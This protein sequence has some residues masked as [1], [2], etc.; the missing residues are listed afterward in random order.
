MLRFIS[1]SSVIPAQARCSGLD[2]WVLHRATR[3]KRLSRLHRRPACA[4]AVPPAHARRAR[5][6]VSVPAQQLGQRLGLQ[7]AHHHTR[8]AAATVHGASS[9]L[10]G[11]SGGAR[12]LHNQGQ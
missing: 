9:A 12:C 11:G 8:E 2:W 10:C 4:A 6:A 5:L 1:S 7:V 3:S